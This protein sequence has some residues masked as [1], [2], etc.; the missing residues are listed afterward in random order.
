MTKYKVFSYEE[1]LS[2]KAQKKLNKSLLVDDKSSS[3]LLII[4][5]LS[6][7]I[8][9]TNN[10]SAK[11]IPCKKNYFALDLKGF[12]NKWGKEFPNLIS[13]NIEPDD[14]ATFIN[15]N[16][17]VNRKFYDNLL[18]ELSHFVYESNKNSH[19]TAFIFIYRLLE[20]V[21]YAFPMIYTSRTQD[22][23]RSFNDLKDLMTSDSE[24]KELGFFKKFVEVLYEKDPIF[25][26]SIDMDIYD[27]NSEIQIMLF[28]E[29]KRVLDERIIHADTDEPSKLS[30]KFGDMG[31][32]IVT[33]RNRFFHNMNGHPNNIKSSNVPDS[34][35]LFLSINDRALYWIATV[36]LGILSYNISEYMKI[37]DSA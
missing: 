6:G 31:S 2:D 23:V 36:F 4:R 12:K 33:I 15:N 1:G 21:S 34:N 3:L 10:F 8:K 16:K 28:K 5:L 37:K 32:F 11:A 9:L 18:N 20:K 25:L 13:E 22:F 17:F 35:L 24:K 30:I 14:I 19:T 7:S 26:T 29:L 27:E